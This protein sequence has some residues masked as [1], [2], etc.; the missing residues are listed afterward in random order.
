M[1]RRAVP[2]WMRFEVFKRDNHTCTYCGA[3][4]PDV[5]LECDHVTP[6]FHDGQ[7]VLENLRT[8]CR[9][10]NAGKGARRLEDR[11]AFQGQ[12]AMLLNATVTRAPADPDMRRLRYV[13][14]ILRNRLGD[15]SLDCFGRLR[16]MRARGFSSDTLERAAKLARDWLDFERLARG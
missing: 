8:A 3:K 12:L 10:C 16:Q 5:V 15:R 6:V 11:S 7:N 4:A 14:G 9:D 2:K 1:K 13:Q